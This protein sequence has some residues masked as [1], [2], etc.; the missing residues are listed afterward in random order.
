[1]YHERF[2]NLFQTIHS[3]QKQLKPRPLGVT[4]PKGQT[5]IF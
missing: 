2:G 3:S 5:I 1:M 4:H